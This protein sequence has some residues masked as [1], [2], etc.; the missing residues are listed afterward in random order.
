M[1]MDEEKPKKKRKKAVAADD[2]A[3]EHKR[4]WQENLATMAEIKAFVS[5]R[6]YLRYN[7]AWSAGGRRATTTTA[8]TGS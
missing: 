6:Y 5:D 4:P 2:R 8:P 3:G 1:L 7:V